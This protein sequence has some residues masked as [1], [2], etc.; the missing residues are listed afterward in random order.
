M[1]TG[2][3]AAQSGAMMAV[4][5]TDHAKP[6]NLSLKPLR[7]VSLEMISQPSLLMTVSYRA[8]ISIYSSPFPRYRVFRFACSIANRYSLIVARHKTTKPSISTT[9]VQE[10]LGCTWAGNSVNV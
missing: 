10:F 3:A 4:R 2:V 7:C 6:A 5:A 8:Y 1:V 9:S